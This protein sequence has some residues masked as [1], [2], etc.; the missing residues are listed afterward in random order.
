MSWINSK[1]FTISNRNGR[2]YV[3][4][5]SNAGNTEINIPASIITKGQAAAWLKAHPDKVRNPTKYRPKKAQ[6]KPSLVRG[7]FLLNKLAF[8]LSPPKV[9]ETWGGMGSPKYFNLDL[10]CDKFRASLKDVTAIGSGRQGKVYKVKQHGDEFVIKIAPYDLM[11]KKRGETQPF[12][13]EFDIQK[14]IMDVAPKGVVHVY[15]TFRCLNFVKPSDLDMKN[16]QNSARFDKSRQS[17]IVMEYCDMGSVTSW[18]RK[19]NPTDSTFKKMISQIVG[20]LYEIR[21]KYPYFNHNDL[22]MDNVF[23]SKKRGFLL[24][25]FGWARLKAKDTNPAVNTANGTTTASIYGVGP[26]TDPRYDTHLFL[27]EIRKWISTHEPEKYSR[28]MAFLDRAVP[29]GYRGKSDVHVGEWRLKYGD[30]CPGLPTIQALLRDPYLK[31]GF[32]VPVKAPSPKK[33][34]AAAP[35]PKKLITSPM[36]KAA[37]LKLNK[38]KKTALNNSVLLALS[39]A[40]FLKLSPATRARVAALRAA[41]PKKAPKPKANATEKKK[42]NAAGGLV[43]PKKRK[44]IP[45]GLLKTNKFN[46]LVTKIYEQR[47]KRAN[48]SFNNAWSKA[49]NAA[50]NQIRNRINANKQPFTP[51][52]VKARTKTPSPSPRPPTPPKRSKFNYKLSPSSGRAKIRAPNSGRYVYAN[53]STISLEYLKSIAATMGVNIKGVRSKANIAKRIFSAKNK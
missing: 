29:P 53:G 22:H 16:V 48:E 50:I 35:R 12:Q 52:P 25:D 24:G 44:P 15:K 40:N 14:A 32:N 42:T 20:T 6:A 43:A 19:N 36:L 45:P 10:P 5:R 49:R 41:L 46:K 27:N 11:A 51:S 30:P 34:E 37:L 13:I 23:V 1:Q 18:L 28:T 4:R 31:G 38:K 39:A 47:N 8:R 17:I 33:L 21:K 9:N 3:F 7:G 26:K 2:H